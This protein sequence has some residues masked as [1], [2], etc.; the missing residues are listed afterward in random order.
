[1]DIQLKKLSTWF[2]PSPPSF[3]EMG[4]E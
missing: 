4:L 2:A 1:M 3:Y